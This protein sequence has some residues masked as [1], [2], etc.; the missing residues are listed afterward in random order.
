M[1]NSKHIE[2][3]TERLREVLSYDPQT[4][5]FVWMVAAGRARIGDIAGSV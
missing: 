5:V 3:T 4:G 1:A 2:L